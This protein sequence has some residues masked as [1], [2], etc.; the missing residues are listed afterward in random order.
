VARPAVLVP[1]FTGRPGC[2]GACGLGP[3]CH[4]LPSAGQVPA[5]CRAAGPRR[6]QVWRARGPRRLWADL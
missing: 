2:A 6:V 4:G 1:A 5:G 3:P